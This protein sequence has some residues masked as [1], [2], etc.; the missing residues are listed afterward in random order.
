[1]RSNYPVAEF[2][3]VKLYSIVITKQKITIYSNILFKVL[4]IQ[5]S[6]IEKNVC[7]KRFLTGREISFAG[8]QHATVVSRGEFI[9]FYAIIQIK[10]AFLTG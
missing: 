5:N 2:L 9:L 10:F 7:R 3:K 8:T 1:M 4:L 6:K